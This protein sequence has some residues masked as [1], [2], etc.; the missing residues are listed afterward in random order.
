M[1]PSSLDGCRP[2]RPRPSWSDARA[3]S[4]GCWPRPIPYAEWPSCDFDERV[5]GCL[6]AT[7]LCAQT[8]D[9]PGQRDHR[10]ALFAGYPDAGGD[11]PGAD[12]EEAPGAR[13]SARLGFFRAKAESLVAGPVRRGSSSDFDGVVPG[14]LEA[15]V[16]RC[17]GSVARPPTWCSATPSACP[18]SP[19]TPT[20]AG[21]SAGSAGPRRPTRSRSSTRSARCSR[22]ATGPCSAIT[23]IWHGRRR[24][25][26]DK[27]AC[28]A[29]PLARWCP[30]YGTGPTDPDE[31]AK[32]VR[33]EGPGLSGPLTALLAVV[34]L[35]AGCDEV[36]PPGR[37]DVDVDTAELR[38]IK[39]Q[40]RIE[41]CAPGPGN[42]KLSEPYAA[43]PSAAGP[44]VDLSTLRGPMVINTWSSNCG[45]CRT[46]MPALQEF[47]AEYGEQVAVLGIDFLDVQP[48]AA[49]AVWP[50][51]PAPATRRW[52]TRRGCCWSRTTCGSSTPTRS[53]CSSTPTACRAP[54]GRRAGV[55]RRDPGHGQPAPGTGPVT[56]TALPERLLPVEA[57]T[58]SIT[59]HDLTRFV[60]P[61]D[62]PASRRR[63]D[64]LR[65]RPRGVSFC[66]P[67][68]PTT[69]VRSSV[70]CRSPADYGRGETP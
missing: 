39:D 69:C 15:L 40:A 20:S 14:R 29:C 17:P 37:T 25:H 16:T 57:G 9:A 50:A 21:W 45:P 47:Y 23:S 10:P 2:T 67:S 55:R 43:P 3:R 44:S 64:A 8:T 59:V 63:P 26:A 24:C 4:T 35:L 12:R 38:Q 18:G 22:S 51:T 32:L 31:A 65:R 36:P 56:D 7:V 30:S 62:R 13:S 61:V 58:R 54:A 6:V 41:D 66:S 48:D 68:G 5:R 1:G 52:P 28:G 19:S 27:P 11:E 46:E 34:T 53:S 49:L 42:G 33:T 70:R 60:P